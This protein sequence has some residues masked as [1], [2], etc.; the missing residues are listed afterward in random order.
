MV[1]EFATRHLA[2]L[3]AAAAEIVETPPE[4]DEKSI[5]VIVTLLALRNTA[6]LLTFGKGTVSNARYG[7]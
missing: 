4:A 2:D 3:Q 5:R 1:E 7:S 6:M